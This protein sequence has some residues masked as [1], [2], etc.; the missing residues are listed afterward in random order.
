M[1]E[2]AFWFARAALVLAGAAFLCY[3]VVIL[4]LVLASQFTGVRRQPDRPPDTR[5]GSR[6]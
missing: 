4:G 3:A 2:A 5:S 1:A 6:S